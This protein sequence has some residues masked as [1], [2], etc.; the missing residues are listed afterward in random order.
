[1]PLAKAIALVPD[2]ASISGASSHFLG[3]SPLASQPFGEGFPLDLDQ[4]LPVAASI[5]AAAPINILRK[6]FIFPPKSQI[7][8]HS[9]NTS[10]CYTH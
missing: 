2:A 10:P 4:A 6:Y 9:H 8:E 5:S 3:L 7:T 1:M